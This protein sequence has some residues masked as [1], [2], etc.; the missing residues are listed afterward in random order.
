MDH[1]EN[2][3]SKFQNY[4][5]DNFQLAIV[6]ALQRYPKKRF[7]QELSSDNSLVITSYMKSVKKKITKHFFNIF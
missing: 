6:Y 1:F 7:L 2:A 4:K 3:H 5:L